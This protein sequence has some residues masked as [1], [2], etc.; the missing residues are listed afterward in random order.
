MT[1]SRAAPVPVTRSRHQS[2]PHRVSLDVPQ[3]D[4]QVSVLFDREDLVRPLPDPAGGS[5]AKV[6]AM[7]VCREQPVHPATNIVATV[8]TYDEVEV[9][10]HKAS[11]EKLKSYSLLG[12]ADQ[13]D[14]GCI[15]R[16]NVEHG[17]AIVAT[18]DDVI[19]ATR[20]DRPGPPRHADTM[21]GSV[22]NRRSQSGWELAETGE[23]K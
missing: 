22:G 12:I 7:R 16:G 20:N 14:E 6:K 1:P 5:M 21:R 8:R 2:G 17:G 19:T 11:R 15:L 10:G 3:Y 9:I 13:T 18:I 4:Q 23:G